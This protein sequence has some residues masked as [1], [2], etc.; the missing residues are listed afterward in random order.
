MAPQSIPLRD[1]RQVQLAEYGDPTGEPALW[2]HG[3]GSSRLEGVFLDVGA[4]EVGV[5][6][7]ALDRPGVGGSDPLPGR[8]ATDY[9]SDVVEVLDALGLGQVTVGGLS[10]GGM[11][12]MAIAS[13]I[14]E[15]VL[16]AV[17]VNPTTPTAD[18]AAKRAL[19]RKAQVAYSVMARKPDLIV[20]QVA[21]GAT[22]GR[23]ATA[24]A[25]RTNPD[26]RL[27]D[28]PATAAA[29]QANF[30]EVFRQ[31]T[32]GYLKTETILAVAPWG[33]DH[34]AVRVPV[35]L[36]SGEQ[37][38]GLAYAKVWAQELPDGR[39]IVVPGGHTGL[40]APAIARRIAE[41]LCG[42]P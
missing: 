29:W 36:V 9:A 19:P 10:N 14:P 4:R 16:R 15:R 42:R 28:D 40:W 21:K 12:T 6:L 35:S 8:S 31:P 1:G 26:A 30:A 32:S 18:A 24:L 39:L 5:R 7:I 22:P 34:R 3:A 17:P 23:L 13:R 25:R 33:F 11:Y 38:L 27:L 37:D 41:L 20:K 2:F